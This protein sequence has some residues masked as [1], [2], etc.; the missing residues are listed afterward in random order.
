[1]LTF[2]ARSL[3]LSEATGILHFDSNSPRFAVDETKRG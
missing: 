1:M 3:F 2:G